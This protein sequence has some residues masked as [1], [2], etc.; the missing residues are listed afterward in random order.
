MISF[1]R[2][3]LR[4]G[5]HQVELTLA[6]TDALPFNN[7]CFATFEVRGGRKT[8]ILVD[9][10]RD[11][12][13]WYWALQSFQAFRPDVRTP[14]DLCAL[15]PNDLSSYQAIC[16]LSVA[17]PDAELWEKLRQ[18]VRDGGGL[19]VVPGAE[20]DKDAYNKTQAA[21][22]LLPGRLITIIPVRLGGRR[23]PERGELSAS[24]D[25]SVPKVAA[26]P[27]CRFREGPARGMALLG[28]ETF[29]GRI[30]HP[31]DLFG[32]GKQACPD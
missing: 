2:G 18:Y 20:L 22:Q 24:N 1:Q 8:L 4:P 13:F 14:G 3:S 26:N 29:A 23:R 15:S 10:P 6:S 9:D 25:G 7:A 12:D 16:L 32:Q 30:E 21:Q 19:A 5:P 28:D 27:E 11:A 31:Y 17:K